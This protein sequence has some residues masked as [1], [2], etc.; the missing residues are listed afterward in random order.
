MTGTD[1]FLLDSNLLVYAFDASEKEKQENAKILLDFCIDGKRKC[2]VSIQ[3]L[4]EFF[5]SVTKKI[6]KPLSKE[7]G[8]KIVKKLIDFEGIIK[9]KPSEITIMRAL[10]ISITSNIHYWDALIAATML[11]NGIFHIY[12]ENT[13]DFSKINGIRAINPFARKN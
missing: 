1:T 12:T 4:S 8:A 10:D 9:I 3:N 2:A 5:V 6:P 11:E 13:K 7:E